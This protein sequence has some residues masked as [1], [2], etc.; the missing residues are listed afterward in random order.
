MDKL[1]LG[2][3]AHVDA[4]KTTLS[5]A[6]LYSAGALRKLGRVDHGD[7]FLDTDVQE[8]E[9]GITIFSKQAILNTGKLEIT[10]LDTPGHADFAAEAERVLGVLDC[11]V[12]VVSAPDGVQGHTLTL[13]KLLRRAGVP[14]FL[15]LNKMDQPTPGPDRLMEHL[16]ARLG[17]C[18]VDFSAYGRPRFWE[19][20]ALGDEEALNEYLETGALS[21]GTLRR[22]I[23]GEK[24]FPC[25]FGSALKLEG[26]EELLHALERFSPRPVRGEEFAARVFKISRD[27][28]VRLTHLKVTGGALRVKD[29]VGEE[30]VDQLRLY[31]GAKFT[32]PAQAEAGT[33]CAV[34]GLAATYP[35]QALGAEGPWAAATLEPAL[36]YDLLL[37]EGVDPHTAFPKLRELAEEDPQLHL[38]WNER[39]GQVKVRLMGEV[40]AEILQR[41]IRD[42]FGWEVTFGP[43]SILYRETIAGKVEGVGHF[44]PLRHYAE[45]HLLLEPLPLGSGIELASAC[46][47]DVLAGNWQRLIFTHLMEKQHLGV[48]TGSPLTDVRI[49]LLTGRAHEK[50]TEGGDFRQATYRAVRQGLMGAE[51]ILLEPWYTFR[52]E[53]PG[54]LV[55]RAI[56]DLQR[57]GGETDAPQ[58]V[59]E[60][61]VLTGQAPVAG[62][63]DYAKEV[64]AYSRGRGRLTCESGGYRPCADQA[65]VVE[66]MGYDPERDTENPAGSVFCSH[67]A[68]HEVPWREVPRYAHLPML[69]TR[70]PA[71]GTGARPGVGADRP[72]VRSGGGGALEADKELM[73]IF[74]RTYGAVKPR[75][76]RET[77]KAPARR[78]MDAGPVEL[79]DAALGPECLLVDG[80]NMIFAWDDLK[81]VAGESLD[82]ARALLIDLLSEYRAY[83]KNEIILVFDAY[84]VPGGFGAEEDHNGLRV[85]YT[86]ENE[87]ADSYI[88]RTAYTLHREGK[89]VRV[90]T[91]DAAEQ[92]T[93][94]GHALRMSAQE[95]RTDL[96]A[97][98]TE[99]KDILRR[100]NIRL[101]SQPVRAAMEKAEGKKT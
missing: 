59:G 3:L 37:P 39:L 73:S 64:L 78:S 82:G 34:T 50:H 18:C 17:D 98:G 76:F 15:F 10:L 19:E 46:S 48:L 97:A 94:L 74:E 32:C 33:V 83:R 28:P 84:K 27:G 14:T 68:G 9:R 90:A 96:K 101:P 60:E 69:D 24:L 21:D 49:T 8:R 7:A 62:L 85:V 79:R 41:L 56:S 12:M 30:K 20:A 71:G 4:G 40:Q 2:V 54:P 65:A 75:A 6:L 16:K 43:G 51:S 38:E 1:T 99:I 52:L 81:A 67:G 11:A 31:S 44:E 93:I 53:L 29:M 86:K 89:R 25:F 92:F 22:L 72:P 35:G 5:E 77:P 26:V 13:W 87:T 91:S 36:A 66:A 63:R 58:T 23:A 100:N 45:V 42:R 47:Q 88:E 95:L 57:M 80:Y 61:T 70:S 55:G